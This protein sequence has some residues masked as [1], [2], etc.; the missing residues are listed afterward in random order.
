MAGQIKVY[1]VKY[2]RGNLVMRYCDPIT[3]KQVTRSAESPSGVKRA[4]QSICDT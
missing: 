1:V 4:L 3:G 2:P